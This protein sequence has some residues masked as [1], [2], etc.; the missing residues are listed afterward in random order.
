L[1]RDLLAFVGELNI[2]GNIGGAVKI[3]GGELHIDS[4]A[5]ID[6]PVDFEGDRPPEVSP[7][8]KLASPVH[9][10]K[11]KHRDDYRT[12]HYYIWQVIWGA[13][14]ILFGLVLFVLMPNFAEDAVKAAERYGAAG[15]LGV[16]V[17]CGMPIAACIACV[18]VVGLFIGISALFLWYG[19]LHFGQVIIGALVGKWL[20]GRTS[21]LWP[22]IGRMAVGTVIV[23]LLTIIPHVGWVFKYGAALWGVGAISLVVYRRI[24]PMIAPGTPSAPPIP[25]NTTLGGAVPA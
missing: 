24:Q 10:E 2:T 4:S 18:T 3:K 19:A 7:Q 15:G 21:E 17:G 5:Q 1:G 11:M 8:A 25:P 13:A 6:G 9:F 23:R 12:V 20:M 22:L 14:Y 16:L